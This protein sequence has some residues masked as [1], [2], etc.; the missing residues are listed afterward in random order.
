MPVRCDALFNCQRARSRSSGL[1]R[2]RHCSAQ[3]ALGSV[4]WVLGSVQ[5]RRAEER[6]HA[7]SWGRHAHCFSRCSP[8]LLHACARSD[9]A[10]WNRKHSALQPAIARGHRGGD[11][12]RQSNDERRAR[13]EHDRRTTAGGDVVLAQQQEAREKQTMKASTRSLKRTEPGSSLLDRSQRCA[14]APA[15]PHS[16]QPHDAPS[17]PAASYDATMLSTRIATVVA[18]AC[19]FEPSCNRNRWRCGISASLAVS[20]ISSDRCCCACFLLEHSAHAATHSTI[21]SGNLSD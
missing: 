18:R 1:A 14:C 5:C 15:D 8:A 21:H 17:Q 4:A 6:S 11:H 9:G 3:A 16:A 2:L 13:G 10:G 7:L 12:A 20:R 19:T